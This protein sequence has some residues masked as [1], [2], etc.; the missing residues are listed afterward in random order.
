MALHIDTFQILKE[1]KE[2]I[3]KTIAKYRQSKD[4]ANPTDTLELHFNLKYDYYAE[5]LKRIVLDKLKCLKYRDD[6]KIV[7]YFTICFDELLRNEINHGIEGDSKKKIRIIVTLLYDFIELKISSHKPFDINKVLE[8]NSQVILFDPIIESGRGLMI[9]KYATKRLFFDNDYIVAVIDFYQ[10]C[11]EGEMKCEITEKGVVVSLKDYYT[12]SSENARQFQ[13]EAEEILEFIRQK[14]EENYIREF[15]IYA[16][17]V[18]YIDSEGFGNLIWV[19]KCLSTMGIDIF[20]FVSPNWEMIEV[21]KA[22]NID[23]VINFRKSIG[24]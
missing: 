14:S 22:I 7:H 4:W 21:I 24:S 23:K 3:D 15:T 8:N 1:G 2:A 9:V 6:S 19:K 10:N 20:N 5:M 11:Y 12:I 16:P 13:N 17:D 18:Y